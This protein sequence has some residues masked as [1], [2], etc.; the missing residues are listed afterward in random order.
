MKSC[1]AC[2]TGFTLVE[3][4]IVVLV[5]G[6]IAAIAAPRVLGTSRAAKIAKIKTSAEL[7]MTAAERLR[8]ET[9]QSPTFIG[10]SY[11]D[12][13]IEYFPNQLVQEKPSSTHFTTRFWL[14][15]HANLPNG[16]Y[17]LAA[18]HDPTLYNEIDAKYDDGVET[19]GKITRFYGFIV[20]H[21]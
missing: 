20:F 10:P 16:V 3:I 21:Y 17:I 12:P 2:R 11:N 18:P 15:N 7:M 4:V 8:A 6:I 9:G 5:L 13:Y 14:H 19:T 1:A